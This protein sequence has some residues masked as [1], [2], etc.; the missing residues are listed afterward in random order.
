MTRGAF[1]LRDRNHLRKIIIVLISDIK[2]NIIITLLPGQGLVQ[3]IFF[4]GHLPQTSLCQ[5]S[6]RCK[7]SVNISNVSSH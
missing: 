2:N 6:M 3:G 5:T 1:N 4:G 7:L